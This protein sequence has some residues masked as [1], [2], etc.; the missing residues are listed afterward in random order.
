VRAGLV[1]APGD[2]LWSSYRATT[3]MCAAP[4]FL[5][6]SSTLELFGQDT[7]AVL[8]ERFIRFVIGSTEDRDAVERLRSQDRI[9]GGRAF[10][11][12]VCPDAS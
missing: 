12:R 4:A 1:E 10:R 6:A 5:S 11:D 7:D 9:L 2:W 8:R 3:G